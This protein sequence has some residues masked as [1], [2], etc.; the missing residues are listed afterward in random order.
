MLSADSI[1]KVYTEGE[2]TSPSP[3]SRYHRHFVGLTRY[4]YN[5][6]G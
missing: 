6:L 2:V 5:V 4:A 3:W 1:K